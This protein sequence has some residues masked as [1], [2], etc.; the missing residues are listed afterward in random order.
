MNNEE[1]A[2]I[3]LLSLDEDLAADVMK[4]LR[5]S[6]IRRLGKYMSRIST[7]TAETLDEVA[8]DFVVMAKEKGG[9]VSVSEGMT[10][11]IVVKALGEQ[12]AQDI[13]SEVEGGRSMDNPIIEKLRDVDPKVLMDFTRTEH[14]QTIAL[15]LAHLKP[16]QAA[17]ILENFSPEMQFEITKRIGTLKS[18]PH[19]FIEE[20]ARTLENEILVGAT[21]DLQ[22][23]GVGMIAD[24]LNRMSRASESAIMASIEDADPDL[25]SQIRNLMF[26]FD[27]VLKLADKSLQE[28]LREVSTEDL[29]KALK[30]VDP[31]MRQKIYKNMSKR[32]AEML[33]E[34]IEMMPPIRLSEVEASQRTIIDVVKRLETEGRIALSRGDAQDEFV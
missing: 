3:L 16:E 18:V 20:V 19:E 22:L 5:S 33:K 30:I 1:K 25:A 27:D 10:K 11:N 26:N 14:P 24:I 29:S 4:N 21:A 34:E 6:E 2:A 31:E 8:K 23:G 13:L 15:I 17:E 32:G 7:I 9:M 28:L 12:E